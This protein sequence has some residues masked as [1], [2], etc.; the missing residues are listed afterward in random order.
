MSVYQQSLPTPTFRLLPVYRVGDK[1]AA[2]WKNSSIRT[3]PMPRLFV[4]R[5]VQADQTIEFPHST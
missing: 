5:I 3:L 4:N 2:A 1:F